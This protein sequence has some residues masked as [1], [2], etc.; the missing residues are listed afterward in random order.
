MRLT[1]HSIIYKAHTRHTTHMNILLRVRDNTNRALAVPRTST[2]STTERPNPGINKTY[3]IR[4]CARNRRIYVTLHIVYYGAE[5][6]LRYLT[7]WLR[8]YGE[9]CVR[10]VCGA[11]EHNARWVVIHSWRLGRRRRVFG[12]NPIEHNVF[13][14]LKNSLPRA[15]GMK[16]LLC[17]VC[18]HFDWY[19]RG[20]STG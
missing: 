10:G 8:K 2:N 13:S 1:W 18:C 19:D 17:D 9:E 16:A 20:T 7:D 14:C 4:S 3:S 15:K 12:L 5:Q 6:L 11:A